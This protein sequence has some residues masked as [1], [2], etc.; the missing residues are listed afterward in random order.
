MATAGAE[1]QHLAKAELPN[2]GPDQVSGQEEEEEE[3]DA[4]YQL[5]R[6]SYFLNMTEGQKASEKDQLY[7]PR[8]PSPRTLRY[9]QKKNR[10]DYFKMEMVIDVQTVSSLV[11]CSGKR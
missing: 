3:E 1:E 5:I 10:R 8:P 6:S 2:G 7:P 9:I 11:W 4:K